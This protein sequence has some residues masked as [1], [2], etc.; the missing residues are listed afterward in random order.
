MTNKEIIQKLQY[1][2]EHSQAVE[3]ALHDVDYKSAY[4]SLRMLMVD[5]VD[6]QG[7]IV[8]EEQDHE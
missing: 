1:I 8:E 7:L 6:L 4:A 5:V 3:E 2:L